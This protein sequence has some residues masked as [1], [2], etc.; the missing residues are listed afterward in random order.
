M[1]YLL[2][3]HYLRRQEAIL[4]AS[5]APLLQGTPHPSFVCFRAFEFGSTRS[6][7]GLRRLTYGGS[8]HRRWV[9]TAADLAEFLTVFSELARRDYW[10]VLS[11]FLASPLPSSLLHHSLNIFPFFFY[12][13]GMGRKLSVNVAE[14]NRNGIWFDLFR[15]EVEPAAILV[16][17]LA[18]T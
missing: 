15:P 11:P 8:I 4:C 2:V 7:S 17:S 6:H 14:K 16:F 12:I 5:V 3:L 1:Y 10:N 9:Q 18:G 13:A